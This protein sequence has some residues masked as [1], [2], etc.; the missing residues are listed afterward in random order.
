MAQI[1]L[2]QISVI[3][4]TDGNVGR[5]KEIRLIA[6]QARCNLADVTA[7]TKV[8]F[9]V[10]LYLMGL[11]QITT[12]VDYVLLLFASLNWPFPFESGRDLFLITCVITLAYIPT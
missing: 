8:F 3:S 12:Y 6:F 10:N 5:R 2:G 11:I 4:R 7:A 9:F 1:K